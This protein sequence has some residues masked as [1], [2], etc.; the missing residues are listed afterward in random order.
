MKISISLKF[1]LLWK[2]EILMNEFICKLKVKISEMKWTH[3]RTQSY[4]IIWNLFKRREHLK[5]II[6]NVN[7]ILCRFIRRT[8]KGPLVG[9]QHN[10]C[11]DS[12]NKFIVRFFEHICL[13]DEGW[14][15]GA[16]WT[17]QTQWKWRT[18]CRNET[19]F[20][21]SLVSCWCCGTLIGK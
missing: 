18:C 20:G 2:E 9:S 7:F 13:V 6:K 1:K 17:C 5:L 19:L 10:Q 11:E 12:G 3:K 16:W 4:F 14:K 15:W 21:L 8:C